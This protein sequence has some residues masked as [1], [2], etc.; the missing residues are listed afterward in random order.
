M[1]ASPTD[2]N[3]AYDDSDPEKRTFIFD[4]ILRICPGMNRIFS[5]LFSFLTALLSVVVARYD[6]F[7]RLAE[8]KISSEKSP[9]HFR[10]A[11]KAL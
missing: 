1:R 9:V 2:N 7:L 5:G 6:S 11:P 3:A 10:T 4:W 8:R